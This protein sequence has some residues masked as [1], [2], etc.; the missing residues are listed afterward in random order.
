MPTVASST[1][2]QPLYS[3]LSLSVR[4]AETSIYF[5]AW[6]LVGFVGH[7]PSCSSWSHSIFPFPHSFRLSQFLILINIS[8]SFWKLWCFVILFCHIEKQC[9]HASYPLIWLGR[10]TFTFCIQNAITVGIS[11]VAYAIYE[12]WDISILH[13]LWADSL[14]ELKKAEWMGRRK[15]YTKAQQVVMSRRAIRW[16]TDRLLGWKHMGRVVELV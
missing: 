4:A 1:A 13:D 3:I 16:L 8:N 12:R 11:G 9:N 6:S 2:A 7:S 15:V 14:L 10:K 5:L